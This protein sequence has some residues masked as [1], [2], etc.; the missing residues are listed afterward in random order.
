MHE[1][2]LN[3]RT[4]N[5]LGIEERVR[6]SNSTDLN[7]GA[8]VAWSRLSQKLGEELP[9]DYAE[10]DFPEEAPMV[11]IDDSEN[12]DRVRF[13]FKDLDI[14][15]RMWNLGYLS[16]SINDILRGTEQEWLPTFNQLFF[17][18]PVKDFARRLGWEFDGEWALF[19]NVEPSITKNRKSLGV[20]N[21]RDGTGLVLTREIDGRGIEQLMSLIKESMI[22]EQCWTYSWAKLRL[23]LS[24]V[25]FR[26]FDCWN[27]PVAWSFPSVEAVSE[28]FSVY[29]AMD[30]DALQEWEISPAGLDSTSLVRDLTG[31]AQEELVEETEKA[32]AQAPAQESVSGW[33]A[34]CAGR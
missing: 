6:F 5:E 12:G 10:F 2:S 16:T 32:T 3:T 24:A 29:A 19:D 7:H 31:D 11:W 14:A 13:P 30:I 1:V 34:R 27:N 8:V 25:Q 21:K 33:D 4:K 23:K 9:S 26:G 20:M 17:H 22:K 15:E 18:G 28:W